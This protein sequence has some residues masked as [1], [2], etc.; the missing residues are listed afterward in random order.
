MTLSQ[1]HHSQ[2]VL[3]V[4]SRSWASELSLD[5]KVLDPER[6]DGLM[7]IG[8]ACVFLSPWR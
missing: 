3:C 7:Q 1:L 4:K 8:C 6:E 5:V 2:D